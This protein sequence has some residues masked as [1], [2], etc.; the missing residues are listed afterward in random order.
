MA[1]F[2][3]FFASQ[4]RAEHSVAWL[5]GAYERHRRLRVPLEFHGVPRPSTARRAAVRQGRLG[6]AYECS[7]R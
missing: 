1:E 6:M 3:I 2:T 5:G 7:G 4:C